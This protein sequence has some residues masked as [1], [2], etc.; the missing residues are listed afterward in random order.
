MPG[1][2]KGI[3]IEFD[4]KT[5]ALSTALSKIKAESRG[6]QSDLNAVNRQLR[7]DPKNT[8]LLSQKQTILKQ[9]VEASK[10]QLQQLKD[11]QNQMDAKKVDKTSSAY[12]RVSREIEMAKGQ[13]RG[14]NAQIAKMKWQGLQN[15]GTGIKNVGTQL[16]HATRYARMF[17][18]AL[19]GITLY[20]GFERLKS[21]DETS[22]Q[23][24]VLGYRGKQ[25]TNIMNS[26]SGSVDG[27]RFML[28]DMAKVASGAL[29]SG[30]TDKYKL[31]DYLTRT[32]DLAQLTGLDVTQM[33]AMMNKAY[34][35]GKV[36]AQL[37]NQFNARGIPIYK[38]LQKELGVNAD[39]L[40]KLSKQGKISFDD[41]YR[42]TS[43]YQG[44]AQKM[45]T[46]TLP[47]ALT[48]LQ[49]QFGLIGA[50]F[51]SGVYEP[52]RGGIKGLVASIKELRKSGTFKEWGQDLGDTVKYFITY[53][54]EGKASM[55]GMS[56]RARNLTSAVA[57]LIQTIGALVN[58]FS[59][60][61]PQLQGVL[62]LGVLLGGPVLSGV[63]SA[64]TGFSTLAT[65]I[66]TFTMN[67]QAGVLNTG[68]LTTALGGLNGSIGILLNPLTLGAAALGAWALGINKMYT[69][70]HQATIE[71]D[72]F[73]Q[74]ANENITA[75]ENQ[76]SAIDIYK[77]KLDEL[78][79]KENKS[80]QDKALI[81]A[82]VDKLNGAVSG[83]NLKYNE[84][85]DKLN[86]T[87]KA[88]ANKI[89]N[90]KKAALVKAYEDQI[91]EAAKKEADAQ[92]ELERLYEEQIQIKKKWAD[93][94]DH[95]R[96][97][98][99]GFDAKMA[100][101][102]AKIKDQKKAIKEAESAMNQWA[103]KAA[104]A[105]GK[106]KKSLSS[107]SSTA[108][109]EGR[110]VP[111]NYAAGIEAGEGRVKR[112][113]DGLGKK[114]KSGLD[115]D[116]TGL[117]NDFASGFINGI[118]NKAAEVAKAAASFVRRAINAAKGEQESGSPSRVME[119]KG[120]DY[121]NGY[122]L[123]IRNKYGAVAN[124]SRGMVMAAIG[125]ATTPAMALTGSNFASGGQSSSAYTFYNNFTINNADNAQAVAMAIS[126]ELE[127]EMRTE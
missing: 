92:I 110:A 17:A 105:S 25:L 14:F 11:V 101:T 59:K 33:G 24:E 95:S 36:Q 122:I 15:L 114:A 104:E 102:N 90:Y 78:V 126:M 79:S 85:K 18:A 56:E 8:E 88:I 94:T 39:E 115:V 5:T 43:R 3:T 118:M 27:T 32:A 16:T 64:I 113:S 22:K 31:N 38:L 66:Q 1:A 70:T 35:K 7:F 86:Q 99:V 37:M 58:G 30:V 13:I 67:A 106:T 73:L 23:L 109:K 21:L 121:G 111:K 19:A 69:E 52:L 112:A 91:T 26:V 42:A 29:G 4:A 12:M 74:K 41:L 28:Q 81:K 65:N 40:Q 103:N 125:Q 96:T 44:L 80:A 83:L 97:A 82:Y 117:G 61:P 55:D 107:A 119:D 63:G 62:A 34:S 98:Q 60:L 10:N 46:E 76:G 48:V 93:S 9:R 127:K 100:E 51:L 68:K 47:G 116:T 49:Q 89:E 108:S 71:M 20:K 84:E 45:G 120:E 53:F 72:S 57:P 124:A 6:L 87:S 123:G 50:D 77:S 2:I 54:N 75:T